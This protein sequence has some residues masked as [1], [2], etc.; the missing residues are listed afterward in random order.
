M[1][2]IGTHTHTHTHT[3]TKYTHTHTQI[4][5]THTHTHTHIYIYRERVHIL[6]THIYTH[7]KYAR[8]CVFPFSRLER[9]QGFPSNMAHLHMLQST[10]V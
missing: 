8:V 7:I 3:H 2:E 9:G 6:S 1:A 5:H 4:T 10:D